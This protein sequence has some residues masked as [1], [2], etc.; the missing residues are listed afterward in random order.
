[1]QGEWKREKKMQIIKTLKAFAITEYTM[2]E[3][4]SLGV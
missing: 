4:M 3:L 1:M 2:F